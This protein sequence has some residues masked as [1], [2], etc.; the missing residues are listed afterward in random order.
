MTG[1][2]IANVSSYDRLIR[3]VIGIVLLSL[4]FWGPQSPWGWIGLIPLVTGLVGM[5]PFYRALG[6]STLPP[7]R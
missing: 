7:R 5:C 3:V 4:V 6:M 1:F 2:L